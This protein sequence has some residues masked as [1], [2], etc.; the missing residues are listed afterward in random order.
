[1]FLYTQASPA[2]ST[3]SLSGDEDDDLNRS[4]FFPPVTPATWSSRL[5]TIPPA[6]RPPAHS[7]ASQLPPELLINIFKYLHNPSDIHSSLL[8]SRAWCECSVELLWHKPN[9]P[10]FNTLF[11][12]MKSLTR[13]DC[14]FTYAHFIRRLNLLAVGKELIDNVFNRLVHCTRLERITLVGCTNLSDDVIARTVPSFPELVAIDLSGVGSVTDRT[15]L[16]L[17]DNCSKL[18]GVNLLNCKRVTSKSVRALA[19]GCPLLRRV[20]LSGLIELTDEPVH[21]LAMFTPLVL[22]IDLGGCKYIT[23]APIRD[24]WTHSHHM[25]EMRLAQCVE[26]TDAAF[27]APPSPEMQISGPNPFPESHNTPA[28]EIAPLILTRMFE[29]LR[30]LDLTGCAKVTDDAIEG[31]VACAPKIRNLVLSKCKGLTDRAVESICTLGKHLHYL[32]LGHASSIT[33]R[34]VKTLARSC[35]RLRYIDL[36]NCSLLTDM[37]VF[38]LASLPKLRRIGLVRVSNLTDEAI[39]ALGDRH[40][41]LERVHLSYCD[42]ITVMAIHFLLQK[43]HKLNH[44]SLTGV[45]AFRRQELQVFCRTPPSEFNSSQR[46][47]FCVYSAEGIHELRSFLMDLFNSITEELNVQT[48]FEE[49]DDDDGNIVHEEDME[50]DEDPPTPTHPVEHSFGQHPMVR[51]D[52]VYRIHRQP[53]Q[54]YLTLAPPSPPPAPQAQPAQPQPG[55]SRWGIPFLRANDHSSSSN[56]AGPRPSASPAPSDGSG[57]GRSA[58]TFFRTFT[59]DDNAAKA[60]SSGGRNGTQTPDLVFAEIGHGRGVNGGS[61]SWWSGTQNGEPV[62]GP[63]TAPAAT[64][65]SPL[66]LAQEQAYRRVNGN[67]NGHGVVDDRHQSPQMYSIVMP[68]GTNGR[69]SN[70]HLNHG[71][72]SSSTTVHAL[73][74]SAGNLV[75]G[76]PRQD[77]GR[78]QGTKELHDSLAPDRPSAPVASTSNGT[79]TTD[80]R[81][82]SGVKRTLRN[83]L[84][85]VEQHA[86][87]FLFGRTTQEDDGSRGR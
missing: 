59:L 9:V 45:P 77:R 2:Q 75:N 86:A 20:K 55:P 46:A 42:Q 30:M 24:I 7:P 56:P 6:A 80:R 17:A 61:P 23:D 54:P 40:A 49:D 76:A 81:G 64:S 50:I 33:D 39:Y 16:A 53:P 35:T 70:T 32:H 8:V 37:S 72:G 60:D 62:A 27:P 69:A 4:T 36:A 18:Q 58:G 47:A 83:T 74:G 68:R 15:V 52:R 66:A 22:E 65:S 87:S 21:D 73:N 57:S 31:I 82:R 29:H 25:R 67:G 11:K 48:E 51:T 10:D 1:M 63:S 79:G 44:L 84:N 71:I 13:E 26:L 14:S 41:T 3:T 43:L 12:I 19:M 28:P 38:E 78:S 5:H 34:S 85:A